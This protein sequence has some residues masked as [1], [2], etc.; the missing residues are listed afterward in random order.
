MISVMAFRYAKR[1]DMHRSNISVSTGIM[2]PA[3]SPV[4]EF[5]NVTVTNTG[6]R[7]LLLTG[8]AWEYKEL[9]GQPMQLI[10]SMTKTI[11]NSF[12]SKLPA[13]LKE[14]E[15]ATFFLQ[16]E[17]FIEEETFLIQH[18]CI[19][20]WFR[21]YSLKVSAV[22]SIGRHSGVVPRAVKRLIWSQYKH[23]RKTYNKKRQ[24]TR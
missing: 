12:S 24:P 17:I 15:Q 9:F 18:N 3:G 20:A 22:L 14:G 4:I 6:Y 10:S 16:K 13:E 11:Q 5:I 19:H 8:Y 2:M 23:A 1:K 21:I 7:P